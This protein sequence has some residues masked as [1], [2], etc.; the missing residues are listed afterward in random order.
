MRH[1]LWICVVMLLTLSVQAEELDSASQEALLKTQS[2]LKDKEQ[3]GQAIK[4][5]DSA[6]AADSYVKGLGTDTD[7]VY[8][9]SSDIMADLVKKTNGDSAALQKLIEEASRNPAAF[10][11]YLS[12]EQIQKI[13]KLAEPI[14]PATGS[15]H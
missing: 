7:G 11:D 8:D 13:R 12:A 3:R 10:G 4:E 6:K 1:P 9:L 15:S 14:K 2:L 5:S